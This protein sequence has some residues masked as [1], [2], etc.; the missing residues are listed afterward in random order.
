M[1]HAEC[2]YPRGVTDMI[3]RS[4]ARAVLPPLLALGLVALVTRPIEA[5]EPVSTT[6]ASSSSSLGARATGLTQTSGDSGTGQSV[7]VAVPVVAFT[8]SLEASEGRLRVPVLLTD[9]TVTA[10]ATVE[11]APG[12]GVDLVQGVTGW[13]DCPVTAETQLVVRLSDGRTFVHAVG[14]A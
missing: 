4:T 8:E 2:P 13:V 6:N 11:S 5:P 7:A 14:L 12:C 9:P 3:S 10:R 1:R